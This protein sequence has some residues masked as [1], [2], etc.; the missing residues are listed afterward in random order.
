MDKEKTWYQRQLADPKWQKKRLEILQRDSF[1]CQNPACYSTT[2]EL[3]VHHKYYIK[4][5]KTWEYPDDCL[6]TLCFECHKKEQE[7]LIENSMMLIETLKQKG[8]DAFLIGHLSHAFRYA[9]T[10]QEVYNH[11]ESF[12]LVD[13]LYKRKHPI[14]AEIHK[15]FEKSMDKWKKS[16]PKKHWSED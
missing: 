15:K 6:K 13:I 1:T 2:K 12:G 16:N 3:H 10:E 5:L 4:G 11:I 7:D 8:A 14:H 9:N